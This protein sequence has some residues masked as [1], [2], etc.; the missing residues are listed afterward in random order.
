RAAELSGDETAGRVAVTK[1]P[2]RRNKMTACFGRDWGRHENRMALAGLCRSC[3]IFA[4][5]GGRRCP[6]ADQE[7]RRDLCREPQLR[8]SLRH[9]SRRR[10]PR[11]RH[12]RTEDPTR[13]RRSTIAAADDLRRRGQTRPA[14][15]EDAE[16]AVPDQRA[17]NQ[18][19]AEPDRA[20]PDPRLL[21]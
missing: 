13:P 12:R 8:P 2:P 15:P 19:V 14:L 7:Y 11:Q 3:R 9:V 20:K 1:A 17:A 16:R 18:R 4:S 5:G 10:R 6:R 21:P